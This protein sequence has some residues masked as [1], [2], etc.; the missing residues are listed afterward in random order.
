MFDYFN[1]IGIETEKS[2]SRFGIWIGIYKIQTI[3][4]PI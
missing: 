2:I 3:P 4:N 1:H